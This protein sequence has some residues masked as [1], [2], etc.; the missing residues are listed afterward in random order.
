MQAGIFGCV[1]TNKK[2]FQ[3]LDLSDDCRMRLCAYYNILTT[4]IEVLLDAR[5]FT[6]LDTS[7][8]MY[9]SLL[10][11][12]QRNRPSSFFRTAKNFDYSK[13]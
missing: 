9:T 3:W 6:T 12:A 8:L 5:I 11:K 4:T 10:S 13:K 7:S 1:S 2:E